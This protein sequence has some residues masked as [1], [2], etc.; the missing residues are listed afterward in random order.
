MRSCTALSE[1]FAA[2]RVDLHT[3]DLLSAAL[4]FWTPAMGDI[5]ESKGQKKGQ[6]DGGPVVE[7]ILP[8][9]D[10]SSATPQIAADKFLVSAASV[11]LQLFRPRVPTA[12]SSQLE[13]GH[14]VG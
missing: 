1:F 10:L 11:S 8:L 14:V 2:V 12:R 9:P 6:D 4:A 3:S 5:L 13:F 7:D